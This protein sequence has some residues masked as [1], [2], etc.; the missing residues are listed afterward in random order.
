MPVEKGNCRTLTF[1]E[2]QFARTIFGNSINYNDVRVHNGTSNSF[3]GS[4]TTVT[5]NGELYCAD[6]Y[7]DDFSKVSRSHFIHEMTHVWQYQATPMSPRMAAA[8]TWIGS[9]FDYGEAYKFTLD[10][11]KDLYDY[12]LEQQAEIMEAY[13]DYKERQ[14][15]PPAAFTPATA[16]DLEKG[17]FGRAMLANL[18]QLHQKDPNNPVVK[19][20]LDD[21]TIAFDKDGVAHYTE[22]HAKKTNE[23]REKDFQ[24][25][26]EDQKKRD[27]VLLKVMDKFIKDPSYKDEK[28]HPKPFRIPLILAM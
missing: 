28:K 19:K 26:Q 17:F 13:L 21:K 4:S 10:P 23:T 14:G 27:E 25:D 11:K 6:N 22:E 20:Y 9:G 5:P 15:R 24:K 3:Q 18:T 1:G 16:E 2:E 12:N 7:C 8:A